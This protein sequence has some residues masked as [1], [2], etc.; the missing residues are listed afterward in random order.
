MVVFSRGFGRMMAV[1][2]MVVMGGCGFGE[3]G[4]LGKCEG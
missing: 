1:E 3:D 2:G 4:G